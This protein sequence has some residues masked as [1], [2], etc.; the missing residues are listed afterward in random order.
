MTQTNWPILK[1]YDANHLRR[2]ALP[3]GGIGTGTVSLGGRGDLRDWEVMNRPAKGFTPKGLGQGGQPFFAI[4]LAPQGEGESQPFTRALEGPLD[5]EDYEGAMGSPAA[6][7]GLP[8]FRQASFAAA[9]PFGQVF[10]SDPDVPLAVTLQ[11]FNPLIPGDADLSGV[12]VAIFRWVVRN[13]TAQ[14]W[15][16]AVCGS[17]PNFIG[18]DGSR[19]EPGFAGSQVFTG[20]KSNRNRFH[21]GERLQGVYFSSEGVD[22]GAEAW[23]TLALATDA[24]ESVSYRTS[25]AT[26]SGG[27]GN[28]MLGFWDDFSTDGV[29]ET[30]AA[31]DEPMPMAS[32]AVQFR[33]PAGEERAVT[34]FLAWHF[35][36]RTSWTPKE[37]CVDGCCAPGDRLKNYYTERFLDAW[38]AAEYA[39]AHLPELEERS[40]AF[41]RAF[42]E[43]S[44]PSEVKEAALFNL[45]TLRSQTCFRT[46]DGRLYAWEGCG[47]HAGCCHGSCTHVW[48]YEQATAFLFG[49]LS[50]GQREIEFGLCTAEDGLM[51]FRAGLPVERSA[52]WRAAAADGQMGCIMKLYRDWQLSG[53]EDLLRRL[54]PK[55]KKALEFCWLPGSWDA[56]RD[57][58]MEGCQHNTMDVEYFGPNPQMEGWYLGAL[59]AAEEMAAH[60][61]E[62]AFA[63]ACRGLFDQGKAWTDAQLFNGEYYEHEVRPVESAQQIYPGLM[64]GMGARDLARP[65]FQLASGCLVDQ[66]VGQMMAHVCGLGYLLDETHVRQALQSVLRYNRRVGFHDH[67]NCMRSYVLGDETALLMASY[68]KGRPERPFPYFTEVMTGF[69]Y[70]AAVGLLYEGMEQEGLACFRDVRARYDGRRRSPFDE[71][72]CGHHYARAMVTWAGVLACSG[73]HY[74]AVESRMLFAAREGRW[75]WS[76]GQAWGV[77]EISRVPQRWQARLTVLS[78]ALAL[79]RFGLHGVGETGWAVELRPAAG[80]DLVINLPALA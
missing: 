1:H 32:L 64:V 18:V 13:P 14:D 17:L 38:D 57:G 56:D 51:S 66:L 70:T 23:G 42:C 10:L 15:Q 61:G 20:A 68:P 41:V 26:Q 73:F 77:C 6:N 72:E 49:A 71:A 69:E 63:L 43:S 3:L 37:A 33:V 44:L 74:S 25:W 27:W 80:T 34:F 75:F 12:P 78:G 30:C 76:N 59:R 2:I 65:D 5:E 67:F 21:R 28:D 29:L 62:A 53:D 40:L 11:A 48:N 45:S 19:V 58:V 8:R 4:R 60:L 7:H 46:A 79:R 36:N 39:A 54:W 50:R 31:G 24:T 9:Y 35:P 16:A 52:E 22:P 47:D 55:A